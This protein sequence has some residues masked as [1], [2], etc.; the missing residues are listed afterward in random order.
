MS[1]PFDDD[2]FPVYS[3]A[4]YL[5]DDLNYATGAGV[6]AQVDLTGMQ[7]MLGPRLDDPDQDFTSTKVVPRPDT[8]VQTKGPHRYTIYVPH[9]DGSSINV[10]ASKWPH[11][12]GI[13]MATKSNITLRTYELAPTSLSLGVPSKFMGPLLQT[14]GYSLLTEGASNHTSKLQLTM[15]SQ[16]EGASITAN[17]AVSLTSQTD[18]VTLLAAEMVS[19]TGKKLALHSKTAPPLAA[20]GW[21]KFIAGTMLVVDAADVAAPLA[22]AKGNSEA[23]VAAGSATANFAGGVVWENAENVK[24]EWMA[25]ASEHGTKVLTHLAALVTLYLSYKKS[26]KG[27]QIGKSAFQVRVSKFKTML[28]AVKEAKSIYSDYIAKAS[29]PKSPGIA[30]ESDS[31]IAVSA[32]GK[33]TVNGDGGVALT[34]GFG[35]VSMGGLSAS[36]AGQKDASI[37][38][39]LGVTV[40]ALAGD[41][42]VA[43]DLKGIKVTGK[44]DV[45]MTSEAG[46]A[47][48]TGNL[49]VQLNSTTAKAFVHGKT[50]VFAGTTEYGMVAKNDG[51]EIGII[52]G[53]A[54]FGGAS[55]ADK[56]LS[57]NGDG[58]ILAYTAGS[59]LTMSS[60]EADLTSGKISLT[61]DSTVTIKG[62]LIELN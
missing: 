43:S 1:P 29:D 17:K 3:H 52:T 24:N 14:T 31:T 9:D 51:V 60:S 33:V 35:G 15:S 13:S 50:A 39:G 18:S 26:F 20:T 36:M 44:K 34:G 12:P 57:I 4:D 5:R 16:D 22:G 8:A 19:V 28:S 42:E 38:G 45:E 40:K 37:S 48:V 6:V 55:V 58:A 59:S 30:V 25:A 41:I 46:S 11:S 61:S 7:G 54:T 32:K 49:D 27:S 23:A 47:M 53:A 2:L 10:G 21:E 56:G 62:K